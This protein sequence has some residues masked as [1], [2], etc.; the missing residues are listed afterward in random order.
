LDGDDDSQA[1]VDEEGKKESSGVVSV[2]EIHSKPT[3]HVA[4]VSD[5]SSF[6]DKQDIDYYYLVPTVPPP[7]YPPRSNTGVSTGI[8]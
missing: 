2:D 6:H 7:M 5:P 3:L 1:L 8:L 4:D